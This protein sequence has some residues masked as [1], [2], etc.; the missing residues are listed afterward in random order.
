[1][2]RLWLDATQ[3][4]QFNDGHQQAL[5]DRSS[6]T[7][8]RP[9]APPYLPQNR[10]P[11]QQHRHVLPLP[12]LHSPTPPERRRSSATVPHAPSPTAREAKRRS[13]RNVASLSSP[14][15]ISSLIDSLS[16]ISIPADGHFETSTPVHG[17]R[18]T[19]ASPVIRPM[20]SFGGESGGSFGID[21]GAYKQSLRDEFVEPDDA[22]EPPV[23]R[24]SKRPSG[25]SD[26]TAPRGRKGSAALG[27]YIRSGAAR[28]SSSLISFG[29]DDDAAS[30]TGFSI[31]N[32][33]RRRSMASVS[34]ESFESR[35][36][37]KKGHRSFT[38]LGSK[39]RRRSKETDPKTDMGNVGAIITEYLYTPK[40]NLM[41]GSPTSPKRPM[42][43]DTTIKEEGSPHEEQAPP[44]RL[45]K[46]REERLSLIDTTN[47]PSPGFA[48]PVPSRRSSLRL[49]DAPTPN[50]RRSHSPRR[51]S[52][53]SATKSVTV[54]EENETR[55]LRVLSTMD[56]DDTEV[57]K[58]IKEL[59]ARKEQRDRESSQSIGPASAD[60]RCTDPGGTS[61]LSDHS[62]ADA[63]TKAR[64]VLGLASIHIP[65]PGPLPEK[66]PS[67]DSGI[68][69]AHLK[70]EPEPNRPGTPLTPTP[71]PINY[72]YVVQSLNSDSPPPGKPSSI[73]G[74]IRSTAPSTTSQTHRTH[75]V[76]GRSA[77]SRT[78]TS[79]SLLLETSPPPRDPPPAPPVNIST[80]AEVTHDPSGTTTPV[81]RQSTETFPTPRD[82]ASSVSTSKPRNSASLRKQR[83]RWS[84]PDPSSTLERRSSMRSTSASG[85]KVPTPNVDTLAVKHPETVL[86]EANYGRP[87]S[88]DSD[89]AVL[90]A[91]RAFVE[92][93][94]LSRR[95]R[96]PVSGRVIAFSEVGDVNGHAVFVCVG[97][98]L[99]RYVTAFYDELA[100]ALGLRLIT[101]DR[102][103]VGESHTD[104]T[105]TPL[106]WPD[107]V[108]AICQA[109]HIPKFSIVAHSAGAIYALATALRMPQHIRGRVHLLAPWI[110]PSQ[111]APVG[112]AKTDPP[113]GA[114]LPKS[115]RFLRVLPAPFLKVAN[116]TFL[117]ATSASLSPNTTGGSGGRKKRKSLLSSRESTPSPLP[118]R[119]SA[120]PPHRPGH[121]RRESILLM[122]QQNMPDGEAMKAARS[123]RDL[124]TAASAVGYLEKEAAAQSHNSK[125]FEDDPAWRAAYDDRLTLAIWELATTHANPAVDLLV[126]L[127]RHQPIGFRYQDITRAVVI[128]HGSEDKRVP[129]ENVRW[130]G[131]CMRRCEVRVLD[132][133]GHGLMASALVM[134][135][136]LEEMGREWRDWE[137]A[138]RKGMEGKKRE[139]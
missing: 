89:M 101:P 61:P 75:A 17:A 54:T 39:D 119:P 94:R 72:A 11:R 43:F 45:P 81:D 71:L 77:V 70:A 83:R 84:H 122:D 112:L 108:L 27:A 74:S 24:T 106:S 65:P 31:D 137:S 51:F 3:D 7:V 78:T 62:P 58:R 1:M 41:P 120:N 63:S 99:T 98:G 114:Q 5:P 59:K 46:K 28:S 138:V 76:G 115:Q 91:V 107:D 103:G 105:G 55:S 126:C 53:I 85:P 95:I 38:A 25:F 52:G 36:S 131:R 139:L 6:N 121:T 125:N 57:T 32:T 132:G 104:P 4:D 130:L 10:A 56:G 40:T 19:P 44:N 37:A 86:E 88:A 68:C 135:G 12:P 50:N 9:P 134:G 124:R 113:P 66:R 80:N 127:E 118:P 67:R 8:A 100:S 133:Q 49:Q 92:H 110:P 87:S 73:R 30:F 96:H 22:A 102:P 117:S 35:R 123:T 97:M 90:A 23:I 15:V 129:V 34:R 128:H 21:Y 111:M 33:T 20:R 93:P 14:E 2:P 16:S 69:S 47:L 26:V 64:K 109:L 60:P 18:T 79:K 42:A 13:E 116:S 136:V 82:S 29:R 48:P